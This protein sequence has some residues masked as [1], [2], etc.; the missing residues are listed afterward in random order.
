M[1]FGLLYGTWFVIGGFILYV[2][3]LVF[4]A[5]AGHYAQA[6]IWGGYAIGNIGL[7]LVAEGFK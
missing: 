6:L 5:N 4:Y 3:A 2:G 1:L 7:I